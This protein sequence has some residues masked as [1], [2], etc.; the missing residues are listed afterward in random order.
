MNEIILHQ[1]EF[2]PFSEKVRRVLAVKGLTWHAVEQPVIAPKPDLTPLTGGYRRIP[3]MQIGADIYCDTALIIRRLEALHPEPAVIPRALAGRV[4][5]ME[6]WA[7]HRLFMQ[8][9]PPV[10]AELESTLGDEFFTDRQ[11]MS[12]GF[13]RAG[14]V[15]AAPRALEQAAHSLDALEQQ[16]GVTPYLLGDMFTLADAAVFHCVHF[17]QHSERASALVEARPG[18]AAWVQRIVDFNGDTRRPLHA[19]AALDI[20]RN[21]EPEDVAGASVP[22]PRLRLGA[23]VSIVADDYGTETTQGRIVRLGTNEIVVMRQH[24]AL[25]QLAVHYPRAGYIVQTAS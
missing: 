3:V 24:P 5:V 1:Y 9:V 18:V 10:V 19:A 14:L 15:D 13:S 8:V 11:A 22:D 25:G 2:S 17:L 4:A 6:D 20:A 7:D 21:Q 12:P 23:E 16:L